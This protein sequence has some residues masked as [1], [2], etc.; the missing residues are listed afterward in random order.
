MT[1]YIGCDVHRRYSVFRIRG[2]HGEAMGEFRIEHERGELERFL[3]SLEPGSGVALE[4]CGSWMWMVD[5]IE[6]ADLVPLL[7]N[8]G[9]AKKRRPGH[10]K[11]DGIDAD[12][13]AI[14]N[15]NGT[16]PLVYIPSLAVRDLRGLVRTRLAMR[17]QQAGM[18]HRIHGYLNQ[19]G[20]KDWVEQEEDVEVRDWFTLQAR[21]HL[22]KAIDQLPAATREAIRQQYLALVELE[23][24]VRSLEL[25]IEGRVGALG[26]LR[27]L[28]TLPGV[29]LVL[30]ATIW[31]EIGEVQRFPSAAHL[32]AYSGLLP[33]VHSS[34]GKSWRGP[35]PK[36]CNHYLKWAF[37]EA[38]NGIVA[39]RKKTRD[40]HPHV[41]SLYERV[42]ATTK[43]SGKA[44]VAMARHLAESA[45]WILT[46]KQPYREPTSAQ[47]TS[48]KN[49]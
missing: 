19:Y 16:L 23:R 49:G 30:G 18:K 15:L 48:S 27:L 10:N 31:L 44:K 35:T 14:L 42:K 34:G 45:W 47:V 32:A 21:A 26:W 25:A 13:L 37:V 20:A 46:R 11:S 43:I 22:M 12:G 4:A 3:A 36:S 6:K 17:R 2:E 29:G 39:R 5:A 40:K 38:A 41:V 28:R 7:V 1:Q 24:H 9:E 8:P 33:T